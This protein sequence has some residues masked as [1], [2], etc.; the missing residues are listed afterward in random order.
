MTLLFYVR[1]LYFR[2]H[3]DFILDRYMMISTIFGVRHR[4]L[5]TTRTVSVFG[6][7][8]TVLGRFVLLIFALFYADF[9]WNLIHIV[10][11]DYILCGYLYLRLD[12]FL[13]AVLLV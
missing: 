3:A 12:A 8:S 4:V 9:M 6:V 13:C 11:T 10:C 5:M 1:D 7:R 2:D